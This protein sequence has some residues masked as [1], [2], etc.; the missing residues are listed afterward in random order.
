[1]FFEPK[2]AH[3]AVALFPENT[4][5]EILD[6]YLSMSTIIVT[7]LIIFTSSWDIWWKE[8]FLRAVLK[9]NKRLLLPFLDILQAKT[10]YL[11]FLDILQ[12]KTVYLP[13]L[14][15]LQDALEVKDLDIKPKDENG[16]N[17]GAVLSDA[18]K[19]T[20]AHPLLKYFLSLR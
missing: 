6:I 20:S 5:Q 14:D 17:G 13:F 16:E 3:I 4:N 2:E 9:T 19:E 7:I 10:V 1:M 18:E 8:L 12:A 11:P 15:I